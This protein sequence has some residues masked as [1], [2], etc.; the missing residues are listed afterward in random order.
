MPLAQPRLARGFFYSLHYH[1]WGSTVKHVK[2]VT[3]KQLSQDVQAFLS[4][5]GPGEGIMV[6]GEDGRA[7]YGVVPYTESPH[8]EQTAAVKRLERL[9]N[10]VGKTMKQTGKTED[11]FDSLLQPDK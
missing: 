9:Q 2:E 1:F 11:E 8:R 4:Q 10:K 6:K 5:I 3:F 7:R